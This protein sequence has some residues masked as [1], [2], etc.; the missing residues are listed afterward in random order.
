MIFGFNIITGITENVA[1]N[2]LKITGSKVGKYFY[3]TPANNSIRGIC[4]NNAGD[5]Y[6][7]RLEINAGVLIR[8]EETV[9]IEFV[10]ELDFS[11]L[12][13][14]F[15]S[16]LAE[17]IGIYNAEQLPPMHE[18]ILWILI[19]GMDVKVNDVNETMRAFARTKIPP[20]HLMPPRII[21]DAESADRKMRIYPKSKMIKSGKID[22]KGKTDDI[23]ADNNIIR[24]S[25]INKRSDMSTAKRF[26]KK[27]EADSWRLHSFLFPPLV[28][29]VFNK[30]YHNAIGNGDV[31]NEAVIQFIENEINKKC[32]IFSL[33]EEG[34]I[35]MVDNKNIRDYGNELYTVALH[36]QVEK[37][38]KIPERILPI[39]NN[40]T[41]NQNETVE[42]KTQETSALISKVQKKL[43]YYEKHGKPP[44]L[45]TAALIAKQSYFNPP[46]V[47]NPLN[48]KSFI[49][50][51]CEYADKTHEKTEKI[52]F[53]CYWPSY[54]Y[55]S[56]AQLNWY[57]YMRNCIRNGEYIETDLSYLFV[58]VYEL[59]NQIGVT[60]PDNGL[61]KIINV[62]INYRNIHNKLDRYLTD[63]TGDYINFYKCD[64]EKTF[65][66]LKREGLFLLMPTDMLTDYYLKNNLIMP[67]ELITRFSDYKYYESEF[68]KGE[69]GN[70][71]T[72]YLS[73]MM[74]KIRCRMNEQKEGSFE[75][76][77]LLV[78]G[79]RLYKK[80][81]FQRATFNNPD[82]IRIET[83]LPY[84]QHKS[85]RFFIT[86]VIKEFENQLRILTKYKGRLRPEK[87]PDDI[88]NIC[89]TYAQN[90]FNGAQPEQK[91]EITINRE[92][93]LALIQDSDEVRRRLIE[94]NYE[95]D[96]ETKPAD[97][98]ENIEKP[99]YE[100]V[101]D[102]APVEKDSSFKSILTPVQQK[103][104]DYFLSK[105]GISATGEI[106][107]TFPGV[108]I[109]VE[110]DKIN[111]AALDKIGDLL[112]G[113]EDERWYIMEDYMNDI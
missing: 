28:T 57:F 79:V 62:W 35:S 10:E 41:Y 21:Y 38:E 95:Y 84:E 76:R 27:V 66:V 42:N 18:W 1:N 4:V 31:K 110:I 80:F 77:D 15:K 25:L 44:V 65:E 101:N 70:L 75:Q 6:Y 33:Y 46:E 109:G 72:V 71:F 30:A 9:D 3:K 47:Q 112:I 82:N 86:A 45:T 88:I 11:M 50:L 91:V 87:L 60:N 55:M 81:P 40:K 14:N 61:E 7:L 99:V 96:G 32:N 73:E 111:D 100:P 24:L 34:G 92:R 37:G 78:S 43:D 64:A 23:N 2:I 103:I 83:Y 69:N 8:G 102:I 56:E 20:A 104:L 26:L 94:G 48:K 36:D 53:T 22:Y 107:A 63:W 16:H 67:I 98:A 89:K 105:G 93:L 13:E 49:E 85:F 5:I 17:I 74:H 106:N 108:F 97:I 12:D 113:F 90:A 51:A 29:Y 54:E 59:I 68:I 58:Y 19:Y 39:E 52:P